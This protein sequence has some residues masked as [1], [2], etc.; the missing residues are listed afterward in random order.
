[1]T[2][3]APNDTIRLVDRLPWSHHGFGHCEPWL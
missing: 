3:P 2:Q 1:L